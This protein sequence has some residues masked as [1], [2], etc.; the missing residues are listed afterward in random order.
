M[1]RAMLW[2]PVLSGR[3]C[4]NP[5]FRLF[6][7]PTDPET[8]KANSMTCVGEARQPKD[9]GAGSTR[10]I[11]RRARKR[12]RHLFISHETS[13]PFLKKVARL[14]SWALPSASWRRGGKLIDTASSTFMKGGR[15]GPRVL[16]MRVWIKVV[17]ELCVRCKCWDLPLPCS[18]ACHTVGNLNS[19]RINNLK[20]GGSLTTIHRK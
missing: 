11:S 9:L 1:T 7:S 6:Y 3:P 20:H 18:P 8:E 15:G 13:F 4:E 16:G 12:R 14:L 5:L 10:P 17:D 2:A 19:M